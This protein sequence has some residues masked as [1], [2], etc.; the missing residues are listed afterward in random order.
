MKLALITGAS[1]GVG[2]E[3]CREAA[4]QGYRV[5]ATGRK[6][7][8]DAHLAIQAD[9]LQDRPKVL[10]LIHHYAPDLVINCAGFTYYGLAVDHDLTLFEL[11]STA[12]I[13]LTLAAVQALRNRKKPGVILNVS[14]IAGEI[15]TPYMALYGAA[16]GALTLFSR[17]L[18]AEMRGEDIRVLVSAPGPIK[19]S[20]AEK[21]S[22]GKFNQTSGLDPHY[23]AQRLWRQIRNKKPYEILDWKC[24]LQVFLAKLFPLLSQKIVMR[25]L[26]KR[27]DQSFLE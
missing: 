7:L 27:F 26:A 18:D 19:T 3:L 2:R 1:S 8:P 11:N 24:H 17:S 23:V 10:D 13:D 14:S 25:Q 12:A 22:G 4:A 20:F 15:P 16:K 9:L 5:I 6:H 21:A